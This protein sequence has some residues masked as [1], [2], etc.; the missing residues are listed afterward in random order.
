MKLRK[1]FSVLVKY[2]LILLKN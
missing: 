2:T 1:L